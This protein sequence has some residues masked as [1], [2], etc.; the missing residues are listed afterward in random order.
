M[1]AHASK[2]TKLSNSHRKLGVAQ[3]VHNSKILCARRFRR[4]DTASFA[5]H[6]SPGLKPLDTRRI[7]PWLAR[8]WSGYLIPSFHSGQCD[9][10]RRSPRSSESMA[11]AT[12]T[13]MIPY[14]TRL[15][16]LLGDGSPWNAHVLAL[17]SLLL[18]AV[19][20]NLS[21]GAMRTLHGPWQP[22]LRNWAFCTGCGR[23]AEE[24]TTG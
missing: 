12:R 4:A 18:A 9:T 13:S 17:S 11:C 3:Y 16:L 2:V 10:K 5:V 14:S 6:Q 8:H 23:G 22:N 1:P 19:P 7:R 24:A 15:V 21:L 20:Y